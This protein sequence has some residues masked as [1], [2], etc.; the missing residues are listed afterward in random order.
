MVAEVHFRWLG[1]NGFHVKEKNKRFTAAG[2]LSL[3][4]QMRKCYVVI[5]QTTS[6]NCTGKHAARAA[7]LFF[8]VHQSYHSFV[9]SS[10][11]KPLIDV[12]T[13]SGTKLK[14]Q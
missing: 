4:R 13:F 7:R 12:F 11:L 8:L 14:W 6:K 10:F 3:E 2:A 1:A 5:Y 9:T